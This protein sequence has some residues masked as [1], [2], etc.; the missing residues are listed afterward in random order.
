MKHC[1]ALKPGGV[2]DAQANWQMAHR[3]SAEFQNWLF[4]YLKLTTSG[5]VLT[6]APPFRYGLV[7]DAEDEDTTD[8][9][10]EVPSQP[11]DAGLM[12]SLYVSCKESPVS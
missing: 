8:S 7:G 1:E 2:E 12:R 5:L 4:V 11:G 9:R 10:P 6:A 3:K